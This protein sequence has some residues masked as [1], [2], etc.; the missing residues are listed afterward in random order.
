MKLAD[1]VN[2]ISPSMTFAI[3]NKAK[4]L[5]ATGVDVCDFSVGEPDFITPAMMR[6]AAKAALDAGRT[7]YTPTAGLPELRAAIAAKL[8]SEND[9]P[10]APEQILVTAGGKQALY[11][12]LAVLLD[13]GDEA[14][15]PTPA[16]VTYQEIVTLHGAQPVFVE[17]TEETGLKLTTAQLEM[18]ITPRTRVLILNAPSN[19]TGAVYAPDELAALAEVLVAHQIAVVADEI[20]EKLVYDGLYHKSIGSLSREVFDLTVTI[21]GFSKAY[22]ATGWRLGYAAAPLPAIEAATAVQDHSTSGANTFAQY[23]ALAGL[24]SPGDTIEDMRVVFEERRNLVV[25]GLQ[26]IPGLTCSRPGGAFYVFPNISRTG[27]SSM[28]FCKRLLEQEAVA[29]VPGLAFGAEGYIRISY[30][31]DTSTLREG[32][33]RLDR[34]VRSL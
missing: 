8:N 17:T 7:K 14:I 31:T 33:R 5:K 4:S 21:N 27:L 9:L 18:A 13:P 29:A 10:Y 19:P 12:M 22:A 32:L 1:R 3:A 30:A 23:G 2:R 6:E 11:N 34:F 28:D 15:I 26:A 16:W 24:A 25:A 20:Y